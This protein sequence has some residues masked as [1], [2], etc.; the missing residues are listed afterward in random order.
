MA[1]L[2]HSDLLQALVARGLIAAEP[3][4]VR[5]TSGN[6][7]RRPD[8]VRSAWRVRLQDGREAKLTLGAGLAALAAR[9]TEFARICPAIAPAPVFHEQLATGVEAFAET[10]FDGMTLDSAVRDHLLPPEAAQAALTRVC[11]ALKATE[12]VSTTQAR[13]AEWHRFCEGLGALPCW[14]ENERHLLREAVLPGLQHELTAPSP[15]TRWTNGD[16]LGANLLIATDGR[17]C[18]VDMEYAAQT[19]FFPE[20]A[21]RFHALSEAARLQPALFEPI[22]PDPGPAWHLFLW[23]RQ[24]QL[25]SAANTEQ[26]LARTRPLRLAVIR[27]L[28]EHVLAR[29]L[30]DWS[31]PAVE[32]QYNLEN[33][34][35]LPS[36]DC[37]VRLSGWC[38]VGPP[39]RLRH[40][41]VL[42]AGRR[43]AVAPP[44]PRPDVQA[45]FDGDPRALNTG[46]AADLP[47]VD[48][49]ALLTLAAITD[50]GALLPFQT[51]RTAELPWRGPA[52]AG[53][54]DWAE[55]FD[56]EPADPGAQRGGPT[57]ML[58]VLLPVHNTPEA[59]LRDCVESVRRQRHRKWE[60]CVVDDGSEAP[61]VRRLLETTAVGDPRIRLRRRDTNGGIAV[62]TN[63]A[64]AM[65][66]GDYVL[67]LDHDD[68]LRPH[69][70]AELAAALAEHPEWDAVFSDED[71]IT[72]DGRRVIPFFKPDYSPEFLLGAMY[73]GHILVV[74]TAIARAVGGFD[75]AF[76]G[77]QDYEF[78]L[79]V[80]ERTRRI[81]HLPRILY[82]WRQS[83]DSSALRGNAKGDM[84]ARQAEAVRAHLA[85]THQRRLVVPLGRHRVLVR[86]SLPSSRPTVSVIVAMPEPAAS[87]AGSLKPRLRTEGAKAV[88][89]LSDADFAAPPAERLRRLADG[90][91]GEVLVLLT[92]IPTE[93]SPGWLDELAALATLDDAG[94]VAPILL[95]P[96]GKVFEAGWAVGRGAVTPL[97]RGFDADN[98]G[99]NGSLCCSRET[100]G[101]SCLCL[102][103]RRERYQGVGGI[104]PEYGATLG[105]IDLCLRLA[106]AGRYNRVAASARVTVAQA[107]DRA[108]DLHAHWAA[109]AGRWRGR[110]AEA[111][112][113]FNPNFDITRG[114]YRLAP[115][116]VA[117][118]PP[119]TERC[120]ALR[121]NIDAPAGFELPSRFLR[122]HGW[123]FAPGVK[124]AAMR[125]VV[126]GV[127]LPGQ[128]GIRRPDVRAAWPDAPDDQ[129]GFELWTAVPPGQ[130]Q[131]SLQFQD[132]AGTWHEAT[133]LQL[134]APRWNRPAWL[135][136]GN[137]ADLVA[138]QLGLC[139]A[140]APR[141]L[142]VSRLPAPRTSTEVRPR[143]A[144]VTPSF[145]QGQFLDEAISSV[146]S[147]ETPFDYVVQDGGSTDGSAEII[148]RHADRLHAWESGP[149]RGQA[150]AIARGF[151]KTSG[152]PGDLMAW[153]NADDFYL[154]G[155]LAFVADYF[156]R[157]PQVDVLY[158]NRV[159]VDETGREIR[160]WFL[161]PHDDALLRLNDYVPQE[162]LFWRRRLWDQVGGINPSLRFAI[163]WD[164]LLRFQ[165]AGARI[166][167]LPR[168][169]ACFRVHSRQKT[170]AIMKEVGQA[171]IDLLRERTFG[172]RMPSAEIEAH[173]VL[174]SYLRRS[175]FIEFLWTLGVR[176]R[177]TAL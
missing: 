155:V 62:A 1:D 135:P 29:P 132:D 60:L 114:D 66:E 47:G 94:A 26:Y 128:Y 88:E 111:D 46:F 172:R 112:P 101:L 86:A 144:I 129:T 10:F 73:V 150:D 24:L 75:P 99:Y 162:S 173:P 87:L 160:R 43:R 115:A 9:A 57:P 48:Y 167:H 34:W 41:A 142:N 145:H 13:E 113:F 77:V 76:D 37:E 72:A 19:H 44:L 35:W 140:H 80:S 147:E 127:E 3:A 89:I 97:M 45:H 157:H 16:F 42:S 51:G 22:L 130:F 63:D 110:L 21:A 91:T 69:A 131:G 33:A 56:P 96:D 65:A 138:F 39:F 79:R 159:V 106:E 152:E 8:P 23:L 31:V 61:Q 93:T 7:D 4:P 177:W 134:R 103:V 126:P 28:A 50:D 108:G 118:L 171:E 14:S 53:Y 100:S 119:R 139:P 58:S 70:L 176:T 109:F 67:L 170:T 74:R 151:A 2:P 154:P 84:D 121:I 27:R 20:D 141:N 137:A 169:L 52:I 133:T 156:A 102:A 95:T 85:R 165:E 143:V 104:R 153:L 163:D 166:V 174:L 149:D 105:A 81:A 83:P 38:R 55:R 107:S 11:A 40:V 123:C 161:P 98:D 54:A 12:A 49:D 158:G 117:P 32:I 116:P 124:L 175:A 125:L 6:L 17:A 120:P 30:P 18:L 136:G 5:L 68:V 90:A 78:L 146:L 82:H 92:A 71:K 15:V 148:H 25:E 168:F 164:L 64:L 36:A 59:F 122:M